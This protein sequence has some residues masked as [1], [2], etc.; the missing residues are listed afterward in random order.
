MYEP[1]VP[2]CKQLN[3]YLE[4][5]ARRMPFAK[6]LRLHAFKA[7]NNMDPVALPILMIHKGGELLHNL[8]RVSDDLPKEFTIE[9]VKELLEYC[10]VVDPSS[11][12]YVKGSVRKTDRE[13]EEEEQQEIEGIERALANAN[14]DEI[15]ANGGAG[16][17]KQ[18]IGNLYAN[19]NRDKYDSQGFGGR[20]ARNLSDSDGDSDD[21]DGFMDGF[22]G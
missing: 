3:K 18:T 20:G 17:G 16:G 9:D 15:N 12:D 11:E 6:F 14:W 10:G 7:N 2:A 19:E 8:V 21:L 5:L 13:L 4:D 1:Y 22:D